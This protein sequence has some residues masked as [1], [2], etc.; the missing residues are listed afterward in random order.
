MPTITFPFSSLSFT[1]LNREL[2]PYVTVVTIAR[3]GTR[4]NID[5]LRRTP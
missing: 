3:F 5:Q 4:R 2:V 1:M